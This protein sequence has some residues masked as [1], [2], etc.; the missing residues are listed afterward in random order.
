MKTRLVKITAAITAAAF[1]INSAAYGAPQLALGS[2]Q[3][4]PEIRASFPKFS[5]PGELGSVREIFRGEAS[6][7]VILH[8]QDAHGQFEAQKKIR[9][10]IGHLHREHGVRLLFLEGA[11]GGLK[12]E[13]FQFFR[14][15]E[16]N[17]AVAERLMERGSFS[18]G[19]AF[20]LE[21][22]GRRPAVAGYGIEEEGLYRRDLGLFR[23]VLARHRASKH[24]LHSLRASLGRAQGRMLSKDLRH[25]LHAWE[26]SKRDPSF[27]TRY[28][29][30]LDRAASRHLGIELER[31]PM[32]SRFPSLLRVLRLKAIEGKL[33]QAKAREEKEKF[34][35]ALKPVVRAETVQA[36]VRI[37]E[38]PLPRLLFERIYQE[39]GEKADFS[40]LPH[41]KRYAQ[42]LIFRSEIGARELFQEMEAL[43]GEIFGALA[44]TPGEKALISLV[45]DAYLA[46]D[47]L[48]LEITREQYGEILKRRKELEPAAFVARSRLI[49]EA[50]SLTDAREAGGNFGDALAFYR[51]A[52]RREG[53]F[54]ERIDGV[55]R[56]RKTHLAILVTG[57]FHTQGMM[58]R[59]R[60]EGF[61]YAT[62]E[63]RF[64]SAGQAGDVAK[65]RERYLREMLGHVLFQKSQ[66]AN[67]A[68]EMPLRIQKRMGAFLA[69]RLG[70]ILKAVLEEGERRG[71]TRAETLREL[72]QGEFAK[73]LSFAKTRGEIRISWR[74]RKLV[75]YPAEE[76]PAVE[77]AA[78]LGAARPSGD[79]PPEH[80][81]PS[82][83]LG[84]SELVPAD[85][86][87]E[88]EQHYRDT[89]KKT[90]SPF[91]GPTPPVHRPL[92]AD[93][94][95][96][97]ALL[98]YAGV[99]VA[100][101]PAEDLLPRAIGVNDILREWIGKRHTVAF[102]AQ[103][104]LYTGEYHEWAKNEFD[105]FPA[106]RALAEQ[107]VD[108]NRAYEWLSRHMLFL[109]G[110]Y[111]YY[112]S[113]EF[114]NELIEHTAQTIRG[115]EDTIRAGIKH[116]Q[117]QGVLSPQLDVDHLGAVDT[118]LILDG[119]PEY[120]Q[121]GAMREFVRHL[122]ERG[123]V[124][125][126]RGTD[127]EPFALERK[128]VETEHDIAKVQE[129]QWLL[130]EG[131][132]K[133]PAVK[134]WEDASGELVGDWYSTEEKNE[135]ERVA[136]KLG[137]A[138]IE[139]AGVEIDAARLA[140]D[141]YLIE[142][143]AELKAKDLLSNEEQKQM[144]LFPERVR[145]IEES[146]GRS[147]IAMIAAM[148]G[149]RSIGSQEFRDGSLGLVTREEYDA[150]FE[151][152]LWQG[153]LAKEDIHSFLAIHFR[154][155]W[156]LN[157]FRPLI[158]TYLAFYA[159][160]E[161]AD[162]IAALNR[163][164][165]YRPAYI[166]PVHKG[167]VGDFRGRIIDQQSGAKRPYQ[168]FYMSRL[169]LATLLY[170]L[171]HEPFH[172]LQVLY[173]GFRATAPPM[174]EAEATAS[175]FLSFQ[176]MASHNPEI[177]VLL[178]LLSLRERSMIREDGFYRGIGAH[179]KPD[180]AFFYAVLER[181]LFRRGLLPED[182]ASRL[183]LLRHLV[184]AR[185]PRFLHVLFP[186]LEGLNAPDGQRPEGAEKLLQYIGSSLGNMVGVGEKDPVYVILREKILRDETL[187]QKLA[188]LRE[189]GI[190]TGIVL[191]KATGKPAQAF[192]FD[193][194]LGLHVEIDD[195]A[196]HVSLEDFKER[197]GSFPIYFHPAI[198]DPEIL[199]DIAVHEITETYH[200][201][202]AL[203]ERPT[204]KVFDQLEQDMGSSRGYF[205]WKGLQAQLL[206][207]TGLPEKRKVRIAFELIAA[208]FHLRGRYRAA[209]RTLPP[210]E[211]RPLYG[212]MREFEALTAEVP[213][214]AYRER[215]KALL[216]RRQRDNRL[217]VNMVSL[218]TLEEKVFYL[219]H[220]GIYRDFLRSRGRASSLGTA[221]PSGDRPPEHAAPS[222]RLGTA[223][224]YG[225]DFQEQYVRPAIEQASRSHTRGAS[226]GEAAILAV[227]RNIR[228][229]PRG[230]AFVKS[231]A[232]VLNE[233]EPLSGSPDAPS[234]E[235]VERYRRE[236]AQIMPGEEFQDV[237]RAL[238]E[239]AGGNSISVFAERLEAFNRLAAP[240]GAV[241]LFE[242]IPGEW[243]NF[244]PA[245]LEAA[246]PHG[247]EK[248]SFYVWVTGRPDPGHPF[249]PPKSSLFSTQVSSAWAFLEA[250]K[251][252]DFIRNAPPGEVAENAALALY[253]AQWG[254]LIAK[255]DANTAIQQMAWDIFEVAL[256]EEAR[257]RFH[258]RDLPAT[259]GNPMQSE[260][261]TKLGTVAASRAVFYALGFYVNQ[262]HGG[263]REYK[264]A[265]RRIP[266][267]DEMGGFAAMA[268]LGEAMD[269][270]VWKQMMAEIRALQDP[271]G[272][273][274]SQAHDGLVK[275]LM[276]ADFFDMNLAGGFLTARP[277]A[278][279][280][281]AGKAYETET[282]LKAL[283]G[284]LAQIASQI[285][286]LKQMKLEFREEGFV[287]GESLGPAQKVFDTVR[288]LQTAIDSRNV[289]AVKDA[290]ET[291]DVIVPQVARWPVPGGPWEGLGDLPRLPQVKELYRSVMGLAHPS[292]PVTAG[293]AD[294]LIRLFQMMH[295]HA[296]GA[297]TAN[298][299][300]TRTHENRL[301]FFD[302]EI[303][304]AIR[305]LAPGVGSSR[306]L[307]IQYPAAGDGSSLI[308]LAG[309]LA[310]IV[311]SI[312][313]DIPGFHIRVE[314]SDLYV[315][316]TLAQEEE[317]FAVFDGRGE[318]VQARLGG[319]GFTDESV[320]AAGAR[321]SVMAKLSREA[322]RGAGLRFTRLSPRFEELL[323]RQP[324]GL[325]ISFE[326]R[327]V[328]RDPSPQSSADIVIL[329]N[330]HYYATATDRHLEDRT[331]H[332]E[333]HG[334]GNLWSVER[335]A[336]LDAVR[337]LI[338]TVGQAAKPPDERAGYPGGMVLV[339]QNSLDNVNVAQDVYERRQDA[340]VLDENRSVMTYS[341]SGMF[342]SGPPIE[343]LA[344]VRDHGYY[345][346]QRIPIRSAFLE[347]LPSGMSSVRWRDLNLVV[348][349]YRHV[350]G[351]PGKK[352]DRKLTSL[353]EERLA[354]GMKLVVATDESS[355]SV[356]R[357][358]AASVRP[359][360]RR[361][362]YV[363]SAEGAAAFEFDGE[364]NL[365]R[366]EPLFHKGRE[367]LSPDQLA[368]WKDV[369]R[370]AFR[371]YGLSEGE[372]GFV[373]DALLA[374]HLGIPLVFL[375]EKRRE[376][377]KAKL[378]K[379][380][381]PPMTDG[382]HF[383]DL[384]T[385]IRAYLEGKLKQAG[386]DALV[387]VNIKGAR[388]V[389]LRLRGAGRES[390]FRRLLA[391]LG[392]P[393]EAL[394]EHWGD[395]YG[396][397]TGGGRR[398]AEAF[399]GIPGVSFGDRLTP[400][401]DLPAN[402]TR[403]PV[404]PA[405][406]RLY[407]EAKKQR[408]AE[409]G[410]ADDLGQALGVSFE[411]LAEGLDWEKAAQEFW[412][413]YQ[414]REARHFA[415]VAAEDFGALARS[416]APVKPQGAVTRLTSRSIV[417]P[418]KED[419][420]D[421]LESHAPQT[422]FAP[423]ESGMKMLR[424]NLKWQLVKVTL[425][426][427]PRK[428]PRVSV[429]VFVPSTGERAQSLGVTPVQARSRLTEIARNMDWRTRDRA[430]ELLTKVQ[431]GQPF[432]EEDWIAYHEAD[433]DF[434][435]ATERDK[436]WFTETE[437]GRN[438]KGVV[439]GALSLEAFVPDVYGGQGG[440]G[441]LFGDWIQ[442]MF[443]RGATT[444][445]DQK[446]VDESYVHMPV[447]PLYRRSL[448]SDIEALGYQYNA[449]YRENWGEHRT[450][451]QFTRAAGL[452]PLRY[453]EGHPRAGEEIVLEIKMPD[454]KILYV[455]VWEG[456]VD[457][458]KVLFLDTHVRGNSHEFQ[459][460]FDQPYQEPKNREPRFLQE[461]ALG[462]SWVELID[463]LQ[464]KPKALV[465][466]ANETATVMA[467]PALVVY[468]MKRGYTYEE[469]VLK[470]RNSVAFTTH[471]LVKA[472]FDTF[473][474]KVVKLDEHITAYAAQH[475]V[476]RPDY[477]ASWLVHGKGTRPGENFVNPGLGWP[478]NMGYWA[479]GFSWVRNAV[480]Q[481][482]ARK[483]TAQLAELLPADA[484]YMGKREQRQGYGSVT[485]GVARYWFP[486]WLRK[487]FR[488]EALD[489]AEEPEY[490][491]ILNPENPDHRWLWRR[492]FPQ[493]EPLEVERAGQKS[494]VSDEELRARRR[495]GAKGLV[496]F[497][498]QRVLANDEQN[499]A[500]LEDGVKKGRGPQFEHR[501]RFLE[502]RTKR[503]KE[504]T[505]FD[506]LKPIF[507]WARRIVTYKRMLK[508]I[509]GEHL[510]QTI[511]PWIHEIAEK[512][513]RPI[514][515]EEAD[516]MI[517][518]LKADGA[519]HRFAALL[520]RGAQFTFA[521]KAFDKFGESQIE[522]LNRILQRA[523]E[524]NFDDAGNPRPLKQ[525]GLPLSIAEQIVF[526]P[527]YTEDVA[528]H[529]AAG[530]T[531]YIASS[532][533]PLEASGT[534]PMKPLVPVIASHDGYE[535]TH[536]VNE[537]N[538]WLFGHRHDPP[539]DPGSRH[540]YFWEEAEDMYRVM[541]RAL[542]VYH[543]ERPEDKG[544]WLEM[545]RA[546]IFSTFTQLEVGLSLTGRTVVDL[547][548]TR[549]NESITPPLPENETRVAY[550][551]RGYLQIY[552][553]VAQR[554]Q[555]TDRHIL[556]R[557]GTLP[558]QDV[559]QYAKTGKKVR[560]TAKFFY[561]SLQS[562]NGNE[563]LPGEIR[564]YLHWGKWSEHF[565]WTDHRAEVRLTPIGDGMIEAS[566]SAE[567]E[568][569]EPGTYQATF[570]A[571]ADDIP[572]SLRHEFARWQAR[573]HHNGEV[574]FTAED[575]RASSLGE[576]EKALLDAARRH[577]AQIFGKEKVR[578]KRKKGEMKEASRL[579][580]EAMIL[581]LVGRKDL[582]EGAIE[583]LWL[584]RVIQDNNEL[585][586][587]QI[588]RV[589]QSGRKVNQLL[590]FL[591]Q[592]P[593]F[594]ALRAKVFPPP[595]QDAAPPLQ[596]G[597]GP[598]RPSTA[599]TLAL[600][601]EVYP[602]IALN[603]AQIAELVREVQEALARPLS[604]PPQILTPGGVILVTGIPQAG[605]PRE[606]R[607]D[608]RK[609]L[610]VMRKMRPDL[611]F[612]ALIGV[613]ESA[614]ASADLGLVHLIFW[615]ITW[616]VF[617]R[618]GLLANPDE[619]RASPHMRI[620]RMKDGTWKHERYLDLIDVW[621]AEIED[622]QPLHQFTSGIVGREQGN[623]AFVNVERA[624]RMTRDKTY[625]DVRMLLAQDIIA[626]HDVVKELD[627]SLR[628]A[629]I[630][631]AEAFAAEF[632]P[633]DDWAEEIQHR[634]DHAFADLLY[635]ASLH[636][637]AAE[638]A[639]NPDAR[640]FAAQAVMKPGGYVRRLYQS[641]PQVAE[642]FL[643]FA[644]Q[645]GANRMRVK[646]YLDRA[647][648]ASEPHLK[649]RLY[650][651]AYATALKYWVQQRGQ[652]V[653][654]LAK[655]LQ[656]SR[657]PAHLQSRVK[658]GEYEFAGQMASDSLR[659]VLGLPGLPASEL[660]YG[661][662][663]L[664]RLH[665]ATSG[666]AEL[667]AIER[668]ARRAYKLLDDMYQL[669]FLDEKA[670]RD[671]PRIARLRAQGSSL[672][673][674]KPPLPHDIRKSVR[675]EG[676]PAGA[677]DVV[678]QIQAFFD[679][680]VNHGDFLTSG[681]DK[682]I[683][684]IKP[685]RL[686]FWGK[687]G[688]GAAG[689][690]ARYVPY[691]ISE[692]VGNTFSLSLDLETL[693][694]PENLEAALKQALPALIQKF[695][696]A[697]ATPAQRDAFV[698]A[699]GKLLDFEAVASPEA[700]ADAMETLMADPSFRAQLDALVN[701]ADSGTVRPL[702]LE[703][704]GAADV[705]FTESGFMH[706]LGK[707]GVPARELILNPLP[708]YGAQI[709][710]IDSA[711]GTAVSGEVL[712]AK[713]FFYKA[714][715]FLA[716]VLEQNRFESVNDLL[717][718]PVEQ[719]R[720]P[721]YEKLK[722][723][724]AKEVPAGERKPG[725]NLAGMTEHYLAQVIEIDR[726]AMLKLA[727]VIQ[728]LL[729]K[730]DRRDFRAFRKY[731]EDPD[732]YVRLMRPYFGFTGVVFPDYL[733]N[734]PEQWF[735][736]MRH[737]R[738]HDQVERTGMPEKDALIRGYR[739]FLKH[740]QGRQALRQA[741]QDSPYRIRV[742]E[743]EEDFW[744][745]ALVQK[746]FPSVKTRYR[747]AAFQAFR[748]LWQELA[749]RPGPVQDA[750]NLLQA[751]RARA[752]QA[753]QTRDLAAARDKFPRS[754]LAQRAKSLGETA[755]QESG[756]S[757]GQRLSRDLYA[758]EG[759]FFK[760]WFFFHLL[761][762]NLNVT[763]Q[764][765]YTAAK[766]ELRKPEEFRR[767]LG[768]K[769]VSGEWK[770]AINFG[771]MP[772]VQVNAY[773]DMQRVILVKVMNLLRTIL[774]DPSEREG[775][776]AL[777]RLADTDPV[778][779]RSL[780]EEFYRFRGM[781]IP[782]YL[783]DDMGALFS[784][785]GHER[786][787]GRVTGAGVAD[788]QSLQA[789]YGAFLRAQWRGKDGRAVLL[790]LFKDFG[791]GYVRDIESGRFWD[792]FWVNTLYPNVQ[793]ER[794]AKKPEF[795]EFRALV[796]S[797]AENDPTFHEA[798]RVRDRLHADS[799]PD[800][801]KDR[802]AVRR[803]FPQSITARTATVDAAALSA[804][805]DASLASLREKIL[806]IT[807]RKKKVPEALTVELVGRLVD[808]EPRDE[809]SVGGMLRSVPDISSGKKGQRIARL[810]ASDSGVVSLREK[811]RLLEA[812]LAYRD[813][814]IERVQA[815]AEPPAEA[816]A[817]AP[818][819]TSQGP[820]PEAMAGAAAARDLPS[821][822]NLRTVK[823]VVEALKNW[824]DVYPEPGA[825]RQVIE[826]LVA[827]AHR[828]H[829]RPQIPQD[830]VGT[831][832]IRRDAG[833]RRVR[834]LADT[835][836][837][838]NALVKTEELV[839]ELFFEKDADLPN[840]VFMMEGA[841]VVSTIA[842]FRGYALDV[843]VAVARILGIRIEDPV[844]EVS[845][846]EYIA[847]FVARGMARGFSRDDLLG[848]VLTY[849]TPKPEGRYT[850]EMAE[851]SAGIF[852]DMWRKSSAAAHLEGPA[853]AVPLPDGREL[854]LAGD[855]FVRAHSF[856]DVPSRAMN[857]IRREVQ[858][859]KTQGRLSQLL[860]AGNLP[861]NIVF[862][863][864]VEHAVYE[865]LP[866]LEQW[867]GVFDARM[868]QLTQVLEQVLA[869]PFQRRESR[870][871]EPR[872]VEAMPGVWVLEMT[873][874]VTAGG[875]VYDMTEVAR[876]L[877]EIR[878]DYD[879]SQAVGISTDG[880]R[881][882]PVNRINSIMRILERDVYL[883][884][885]KPVQTGESLGKQG[886]E[887][888]AV[889]HLR[890]ITRIEPVQVAMVPGT[891]AHQLVM[892]GAQAQVGEFRR[893]V[894][895]LSAESNHPAVQEEA[896][897]QAAL[898][899]L[900][901]EEGEILLKAIERVHGTKPEI[902]DLTSAIALFHFP[903]THPLFITMMQQAEVEMMI[904]VQ[905]AKHGTL[906]LI[907][908][909]ALKSRRDSSAQVPAP[910][911]AERELWSG[912]QGVV[913]GRSW[914]F[915]SSPFR[916]DDGA[917]LRYGVESGSAQVTRILL[918]GYSRGLFRQSLELGNVVDRARAKLLT[919]IVWEPLGRK[920]AGNDRLLDVA[921]G[922]GRDLA[923]FDSARELT[924]SLPREIAG[925]IVATDF[926]AQALAKVKDRYPEIETIQ[927]DWR[928]IP[929]PEGS[930]RHVFGLNAVSFVPAHEIRDVLRELDRL[931]APAPEGVKRMTFVVDVAPERN[932]VLTREILPSRDQS[933]AQAGLRNV[934]DFLPQWE[935]LIGEAFREL[936]YTLTVERVQEVV[937][938][939]V[940]PHQQSYRGRNVFRFGVLGG[941]II[942]EDPTLPAGQVREELEVLV[943]K[944]EKIIPAVQKP[945][946]TGESLGTETQWFKKSEGRRPKILIVD[947]EG[948]MRQALAD[949]FLNAGFQVVLGSDSVA[950]LDGALKSEKFNASDDPIDIVLL[951]NFMPRKNDG[952]R[953]YLAARKEGFAMPFVFHT[954]NPSA[955]FEQVQ[956][957]SMASKAFE[958]PSREAVDTVLL[959]LLPPRDQIHRLLWRLFPGRPGFDLHK[960]FYNAERFEIGRFTA[961]VEAE[962]AN[963][964]P[965]DLALIAKLSRASEAE[966]NQEDTVEPV[967]RL[968]ALFSEG[969]K[970]AA[971]ALPAAQQ[972]FVKP[973][974]PVK[975]P[976]NERILASPF[977]AR[978]ARSSGFVP[979][980]DESDLYYSR[981]NHLNRAQNMALRL[982]GMLGMDKHTVEFFS[983]M[984]E[985]G[986]A[987]FSHHGR[988]ALEEALK[989]AD[990]SRA[991]NA[992]R[993]FD[994]IFPEG[995]KV[996]RSEVVE[997]AK[998]NRE[999]LKLRESRAVLMAHE[1000]VDKVEDTL[1001]ALR[1002]G[1003]IDGIPARFKE[1004]FGE[1005]SV[1006][1007]IRKMSEADLDA[1008]IF[1009]L[1010]YAFFQKRGFF[1011][1012]DS[1013]KEIFSADDLRDLADYQAAFVAPGIHGKLKETIAGKLETVRSVISDVTGRWM[1014]KESG[1015]PEKV[1016]MRL[1017]AA[1018]DLEIASAA[1019]P[1020]VGK[1021]LGIKKAEGTIPDLLARLDRKD[1022]RVA[1023]VLRER[1024]ELTDAR[1025]E[1026]A[1027]RYL[1028]EDIDWFLKHDAPYY[1029]YKDHPRV[1030]IVL[1031]HY[1032]ETSAR[1033]LKALRNL[1034]HTTYENF[1035]ILL[1036][1037]NHS[1038]DKFSDRFQKEMLPQIPEGLRN[1039][1040]RLISN[1041][1042][1043]L[1044]Y[1045]GANNQ[1046]ARR[1047]LANGSDYVL[1048]FNN[1049]ALIEKD[1050]IQ[1051]MIDA[1052]KDRPEIGA[1053]AP[1054]L[1055]IYQEEAQVES[1056]VRQ[1057]VLST[1058][1059]R[1060]AALEKEAQFM[1061]D[1062]VAD[1063]EAVPVEGRPGLYYKE[1064]TLLGTVHLARSDAVRLSG[1065]FDTRMF[1066]FADEDQVG[1067]MYWKTGLKKAAV[1068]DVLIAHPPFESP[1069]SLRAQY[1070]IWRN[1071]M[1072]VAQQFAHRSKIGDALAFDPKAPYN[1073]FNPSQQK[1074]G[1075]F[1076]YQRLVHGDALTFI[1077]VFKG[1078]ADGLL[1079]RYVPTREKPV[1080]DETAAVEKY[1081]QELVSISAARELL[1082]K[1083]FLE[1084]DPYRSRLMIYA[1085]H[1086]VRDRIA[1087][1088]EPL[1089]ATLRS[1090]LVDVVWN[1091]LDR[1092][1093]A[1094]VRST[1095]RRDDE[1096][1097]AIRSDFNATV[1098][1099]ILQDT[1100]KSLGQEIPDWVRAAFQAEDRDAEAAFWIA[1101]KL[1102]D[1103][1104][1105]LIRGN[1106]RVL[1107]WAMRRF[1108]L[1109][1110]DEAENRPDVPL[1111]IRAFNEGRINKL[1112]RKKLGLAER[1113]SSGKAMTLV[1114][1115]DD[1116]LEVGRNQADELARE[1117]ADLVKPGDF[1118]IAEYDQEMPLV[1119]SRLH[1120][1121]AQ[1122]YGFQLKSV[1123]RALASF[1124][1125]PSLVKRYRAPALVV[1126]GDE[1127]EVDL[1128]IS[1129]TI[1130]KMK[1131]KKL[1132]EAGVSRSRVLALLR[1133]IG[1134]RTDLYS[1135]IGIE[1136]GEGYWVV[1137]DQFV[1138]FL[1139]S[1140]EQ[1141][1142]HAD[1143]EFSVAA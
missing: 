680:Q 890:A 969:G 606:D 906:P 471:T 701:Q 948:W 2:F 453:P 631:A 226:L 300:S 1101:L 929:K 49:A 494:A 1009:K 926:M 647:D 597:T 145:A 872:Y 984:Y 433:E 503:I 114:K 474:P 239:A 112:V 898:D 11:A 731:L 463:A 183:L 416:R 688:R 718:T 93:L 776:A 247:D 564:F 981:A 1000:V 253:V 1126:A 1001:F 270:E 710:E 37:E 706:E 273:L 508:I 117:E 636:D 964:P 917:I 137:L 789:G 1139:K 405:G 816:A 1014:Q 611:D 481:L 252:Y 164:F 900:L 332:E 988:T 177:A 281:A 654:M 340:L 1104:I 626:F 1090:R 153:L 541:N 1050:G 278:I 319:E 25:F 1029:Q 862:G 551:E 673:E 45:R 845:Y 355:D 103:E 419:V 997:L 899:F 352:P 999:G 382:R 560:F 30:V 767:I 437:D 339:L 832:L 90:P 149:Y 219:K 662:P 1083:I 612:P 120:F 430:K 358:I 1024:L 237:T 158:D 863:G 659:I 1011:G 877:R 353:L 571:S 227:G 893:L 757:L 769:M 159:T 629:G 628:A 356:S 251:I 902:S 1108:G 843:L 460:I 689:L 128:R 335:H 472:G 1064:P 977:Y 29:G 880:L 885:G 47:L 71:Y 1020:E 1080:L 934:Q 83:R 786:F 922:E 513:G 782:N 747:K 824:F 818:S 212:A 736:V 361:N 1006:E 646:E 473:D 735:Q 426:S 909:T 52:E 454:S 260:W 85:K 848:F 157:A 549:R 424:P 4:P 215:V 552:A 744:D 908:R 338:E 1131:V 294:V 181:Y 118:Q 891:F 847:E 480:S 121:P 325:E 830:V 213:Y 10:L 327:D 993:V 105:D 370:G 675:Y 1062:R 343:L 544:K 189:R 590:S 833:A 209:V 234:Q 712:A 722:A 322:D 965:Q 257:H 285:D 1013:K 504:G 256:A 807:G 790:A 1016:I 924:S 1085:M 1120:R 715:E 290:L 809:K 221:R 69:E 318:L 727:D 263:I 884:S 573:V 345:D 421:I 167:G 967:R 732:A 17:R 656:I 971:F 99:K 616:D 961:L 231:V 925:R 1137:G 699:G 819:R 810:L 799:F 486:R 1072:F 298:A 839:R 864:G 275:R 147:R 360:L 280:E 738:L 520:K 130:Q 580:T 127:G 1061:R 653:S 773:L 204:R 540:H 389:E 613:P 694:K 867:L 193:G 851:R 679:R 387:E 1049:D 939:P 817:G 470:V 133:E 1086:A 187:V 429:V 625:A 1041:P 526:V 89:K 23:K 124:I 1096:I 316:Y 705:A 678:R 16:W 651:L 330:L 420:R 1113:D 894:L 245:R 836:G 1056:L 805:V 79:R 43:A 178:G 704:G 920:L 1107:E 670:R 764:Q 849:F 379:S 317:D 344:G 1022:P 169:S 132:F 598:S 693:R 449:S 1121:L 974:A 639:R 192:D 1078:L 334:Y 214:Q 1124:E 101:M 151:P 770:E 54:L 311:Q 1099:E 427:S 63:P 86:L 82:D 211:A 535:A 402:V 683:F 129:E 210:R 604:M 887:S 1002:L 850:P 828:R 741:F 975:T 1065:L 574:H 44:K 648:K 359:D 842:P 38:D 672:G 364:G 375:S 1023:G 831:A 203:S 655:G 362:I 489:R 24:F 1019:R 456:K 1077:P 743:H 138:L 255:Q 588:R 383:S 602:K 374:L 447:L 1094:W 314:A 547:P 537:V 1103:G 923:W 875:T 492:I 141:A 936:G 682:L 100:D 748:N 911:E 385:S 1081:A 46:E 1030:T 59:L 1015:D 751:M 1097:A 695:R 542:D 15:Q 1114:V 351:E 377:W 873:P 985:M 410:R 938:G 690:A 296:V 775:L 53:R 620:S 1069:T 562:L 126:T 440:L 57:G 331:I 407:L 422:L 886:E 199:F 451:E 396:D 617:M 65:G 515:I 403:A 601:P 363:L 1142:L 228:S 91:G 171:F 666:L 635:R 889:K 313:K 116:A 708:G 431:E 834:V 593:N 5:V 218:L 390:G 962:G 1132:Q 719:I 461:W 801:K 123:L 249:F 276:D 641:M 493:K 737:E 514:T 1005:A 464:I 919:R 730:Q 696:Y 750:E 512:H 12:P 395:R 615:A 110:S 668:K 1087:F 225:T 198:R 755:G 391:R 607:Y 320:A 31:A 758:A 269:L 9:D 716:Y 820:P 1130:V 216:E 858:R 113:P 644:G 366:D 521:G 155:Y 408:D 250:R 581:E 950:G 756:A 1076:L 766:L 869:H 761:K 398:I 154:G 283:G 507:V 488:M 937:T 534:S 95:V 336:G 729:A 505:F 70:E 524:D 445:L 369:V 912:S 1129:S 1038:P 916:T 1051:R 346:L 1117:I 450:K 1063:G 74:G 578:P 80:A 813:D 823:E 446:G 274:G 109:G 538:G 64:G 760:T 194:Q 1095:D 1026:D 166:L 309:H 21:G 946:Q 68:R 798:M 783:A 378:E 829:W 299:V 182:L 324:E 952:L 987:P 467:M 780:L 380:A 232:A 6:K 28:A 808:A 312:R 994:A 768:G 970:F 160:N 531:A 60:D 956:G 469:A 180:E 13:L 579:I 592:D 496:D 475:G 663:L 185:E 510:E 711:I 754:K 444:R 724:Y 230:D 903:S 365:R 586:P 498:R 992:G 840:M 792:E 328:L 487:L 108:T 745:E 1021:S 150:R 1074:P 826:A 774:D 233:I 67:I 77:L 1093:K 428:A 652:Q 241:I 942:D 726:Q 271:D 609:V 702:G 895:D 136:R 307:V 222:D 341:E 980:L 261:L 224:T 220:A 638:L 990:V 870:Q 1122:P 605:T 739:E 287:S 367:T 700:F 794:G 19:E 713:S 567:V 240:L 1106:K 637:R 740:P 1043:N 811:R 536:I 476:E 802:E 284:S 254:D 545:T 1084:E 1141:D 207:G 855:N 931:L 837:D 979:V 188:D 142:K 208:A 55:M 184:T 671:D 784:V 479:A 854:F 563:L 594:Q 623:F 491:K 293:D 1075:G 1100:G 657:L 1044:G 468:Y 941:L 104:R 499:L 940:L 892:A 1060:A 27:L 425:P 372:P 779:F 559:P 1003:V 943:L 397:S 569:L 944:A 1047:A 305:R 804:E 871:S 585:E 292:G 575:F 546:V 502:W 868:G 913:D 242:E 879:F 286:A 146:S 587:A 41:F 417:K 401:G 815:A 565:K 36:L 310:G 202:T 762:S 439:V 777:I 516:M 329:A 519:F 115:T 1010:A 490:E 728:G 357:G 1125:I 972:S 759:V 33:D 56:E 1136:P 143:L 258:E 509:L 418:S 791:I 435:D 333:K 376:E 591:K 268:R 684:V 793:F 81:A 927:A 960:K 1102:A 1068:P 772:P 676:F 482:N 354:S 413:R 989:G 968:K 289:Q 1037:D 1127:E 434:R 301:E 97:L 106:T 229:D 409:V 624:K 61:S 915:V 206:N 1089:D 7:P 1123:P 84:G 259:R 368:R 998:R 1046:A 483:A 246:L 881:E 501:K 957:V 1028:A 556:L 600:P 458:G 865:V 522:L 244:W 201:L 441:M 26:R 812:A 553:H 88:L 742:L 400:D 527:G 134:L 1034:A 72:A 217:R 720:M 707:L 176:F 935:G 543:E 608:M 196:E 835:H 910:S 326:E 973:P 190:L 570:F 448:V 51:L 1111:T 643:E 856:E 18:G 399:P 698:R 576:A 621:Q 778:H 148:V 3:G 658:V 432:T 122:T 304:R 87:A 803:A 373:E 577:L 195:Q 102:E 34:L 1073:L 596:E 846:W 1118:L 901:A 529:F 976:R 459:E 533:V 1025:D 860:A 22:I 497:I 337:D 40:S 1135:Q 821:L 861:E 734:H 442:E 566:V 853:A 484:Y 411:M 1128:A 98:A 827:E 96:I 692:I 303:R 518:R 412:R 633:A 73:E 140:E 882:V 168:F 62:I 866:L 555:A 930:F 852:A 291:L 1067:Y 135:A 822:S 640:E 302:R 1082:A 951:N 511:Q 42:F 350:L 386:L 645:L 841:D 878:P 714:R 236:A 58:E 1054:G 191:K 1140:L 561:T 610:A 1115:F 632:S 749:R 674:S 392:I 248:S 297:K 384:R 78:S 235:T 163:Q 528:K 438:L 348:S 568:A 349:D 687:I 404:G 197:G 572:E 897:R 288:E 876:I 685:L 883:A 35:E 443:A 1031:L 111:F 664:A 1133:E 393:E 466:H 1110:S 525:D 785:L 186:V 465:L 1042:A 896:F 131:I 415:F 723:L 1033:T 796:Q 414:A 1035:D 455:K 8:I 660:N 478:F 788:Q 1004:I 39:A 1057:G 907:L 752:F 1052:V 406:L 1112:I 342:F 156:R 1116:I 388:T 1039:R 627:G 1008:L 321:G 1027:L 92:M 452:E 1032:G 691:Q 963:L 954:S 272:T 282:G 953:F 642:A 119:D 550:D 661:R 859:E 238:L 1071:H 650:H 669:N 800:M 50:D 697:A 558:A 1134:D 1059:A 279:R 725:L 1053:A 996:L 1091:A 162:Q 589:I 814:P 584:D 152:L 530:A 959:N 1055:W 599:E 170:G 771:A 523:Y 14:K 1138:E 983:M 595:K 622:D 223:G 1018:G 1119:V 175:S 66:I 787:H 1098:R 1079:N 857:A 76:A 1045:T 746:E 462:V 955:V 200:L 306:P 995:D 436:T 703:N 381:L 918:K 1036:V 277:E 1048:F 1105:L 721:H 243:D 347:P 457:N 172:L 619:L 265:Q 904:V 583:R 888:Q 838:Y 649:R 1040:V 982:A 394:S 295:D 532:E 1066:M 1012:W 323:G 315:D 548:Q 1092:W 174:G 539:S 603:P 161:T 517:D 966:K 978:L 1070:L 165:E 1058:E 1017:L 928:S 144:S 949:L 921:V 614:F 179:A 264:A 806:D 681:S 423:G 874:V 618:A 1143:A 933:S 797:L 267:P 371:D 205:H 500:I 75:S 677:E 1007:D 48:R 825:M 932:R 905:T 630:A 266:T 753:V 32:Q 506:A 947:D 709:L 20:L 914:E 781:V 686:G 667:A 94:G 986:E 1088:R 958:A 795:E 554:S 665:Q 945:D 763:E 485:N 262:A 557:R 173:A 308:G 477:V 634:H 717:R 733:V 991:A 125:P 844:M 1109:S 1:S 582:D 139:R 765:L 107:G 495:E